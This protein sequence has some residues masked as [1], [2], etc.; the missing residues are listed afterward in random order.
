ML[1]HCIAQGEALGGHNSGT[2]TIGRREFSDIYGPLLKSTR[3]AVGVM[4]AYNDIDG[5]PCHINRALLSKH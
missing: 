2:V 5:V 1:K 4:A 3:N